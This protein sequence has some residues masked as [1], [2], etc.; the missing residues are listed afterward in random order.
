MRW[1]VINAVIQTIH[2]IDITK[3]S[4]L[5][6]H[7]CQTLDTIFSYDGKHCVVVK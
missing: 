2:D 4:I 1:N 3:S 6:V 7:M 5:H